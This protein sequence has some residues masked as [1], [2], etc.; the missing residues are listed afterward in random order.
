MDEETN[1][2]L[3][4]SAEAAAYHRLIRPAD[5]QHLDIHLA[6]DA[7]AAAPLVSA[8]NI[9]L[10]DP[11]LV[12]EVLQKAASL[13]WV[14]STWAGVDALC[15]Q[16]QRR[17][18]VLTGARDVFGPQMS[19]YMICYLLM[20]E[21]RVPEMLQNQRQKRWKPFRYRPAG[22]ITLGIIGLGSIGAQL[23][24]TARHFGIRVIGMNRTGKACEHVDKVYTQDD[25]EFFRRPDYIIST[26]PDTRETRRFLNADRFALMKPSAVL[27]NVGRGAS[28]NEQ[29]LVEA[30]RK[31]VI[32]G[33]VLDV[34]EQEPLPQDSPLWSL[35]N[36]YVT[37]HIAA[38]SFPSDI[39]AIFIG[40]YHRFLRGQPLRHTIDF[41]AGY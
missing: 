22:E 17:D 19:E 33:A 18:Y 32:G 13:Q 23:A 36:V 40:N 6:T 30:L 28:V 4:L 11:P 25:G 8:C 21:R 26:L 2:L 15:R 3:I 1:R 27:M 34:F 7:Q 41:G 38:L 12:G 39:A 31:G 10:G 29:H 5:L 16:G 24:K 9:I 35:P 14:Q 37:P 20:L